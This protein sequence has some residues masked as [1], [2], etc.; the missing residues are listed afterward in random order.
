MTRGIPDGLPQPIP[1]GGVKP[2]L[3]VYLNQYEGE[4]LAV[5][6]EQIAATGIGAVKQPFYFQEPFDWETADRLVNAVGD[7][8]LQLV[9][10]LDGD[11]AANFAPPDD[12]NS[13]AAWAGAFAERYGDRLT[14]YI[15]WNEPNLASHW[16]GE[17]ANPAAYAALLTATAEAIRAADGNA[18]IV[19][20]PLAPTRE[21][22]PDNLADPLFLQELYEAGADDAFDVAAG[23]PYGFDSGPEDRVVDVDVLNF[24]RIILL[25]EV[26]VRNG[27]GHKAVWAGNWG[28][29]SLPAGWEGAP[30]I[31]G[32]TDPDTQATRTAGALRRARREWPWM[33]F[34]F[35]ENWEAT[36][37]AG[38][39][40]RGFSIAGRPAEQALATVAAE[41]EEGIA[42][43]GFHLAQGEGIGQ[44]YE[45][46][47]RFS[48]A[49]GADIPQDAD[50]DAGDASATLRFW[51]TDVGLRV[52]HADFR[53][54][55]YATVDGQPANALPR[56][57]NGPALVL[58]AADPAEDYLETEVVARN[59][60]PGEHTL[61]LLAHRGWDQWA[62]NGYTVAYHRPA[63]VY[64]ASLV[65]LLALAAGAF[66][67]AVWNAVAARSAL[68]RLRRLASERLQPAL[69]I[70]VAL[71]VAVS[72]WLTWG[73][74]AAGIYRRLSDGGQLALTAAAASIFYFTP[75]FVVYV[76]ALIA[77]FFL[78]YARPAWGVTLVA[79]TIPFYVK[80]KPMLGYRFS[81]VELFL[82]VTVTAW[83][84]HRLARF[85][86]RLRQEGEP[87]GPVE[88]GAIISGFRE[89]LVRADFAVG[90]FVAVA[91]LSLLFTERLDVAVNEWRVVI[92]EPALFYALL[93][94]V[95]LK[96]EE[97][98]R[99][100]DA[101]VLGGV[102]IALYGLATY[103]PE[104]NVVTVGGGL[105]R[106]KSL[107][108]SPN[109]VALYLGRVLPLLAAVALM[110]RAMPR[111]RLA[112]GLALAPVSLALV[113]TFSKGALFLGLPAALLLLFVV[114]QRD[115][116]RPVWPWLAGM[117]IVAAAA[118][119]AALNVPALASRLDL[120]SATSVFRLNLWQASVNMFADHPLF[121]VGL[122]NFLY[123]YRGRYIFDA[124]W[125]EPNLNHPHNIVLDFATRLGTLGLVTGGWLFWSLGR[126]LHQLSDRVSDMWRPVAVGLAAA[127]AN[128]LAHGLVD[129]SFFLVDLSF[130]FYLLLGVAVWLAHGDRAR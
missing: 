52:R 3:N 106:L 64:W 17:P 87:V 115:A 41:M 11:P 21:S 5:E 2:A 89:R 9:P 24:S 14:Y 76:V 114:W 58:T 78:V 29:N 123:A 84:A 120:R 119:V 113:L 80:P 128:M 73:E 57:E 93:R 49:F 25:R 19:A 67:V 100:L 35:L 48:P 12:P 30:S 111:R 112:Y 97:M 66:V 126:L 116:S 37:P 23:K 56:D 70:L 45:G 69:T 39:P 68:G 109:N 71:V 28:W 88:I 8:G 40:R 63:T 62:L 81:P 42:Y 129:H 77:L 60:E 44:H 75:F 92:V 74:Q 95:R 117:A 10:L 34:M 105:L 33:G 7:H 54:R 102:V 101:F 83:A 125:Q 107:F 79:F 31:W 98:Q 91:T 110:G 27:N 47:W 55:L 16:G 18:V 59:L 1:Y 99:V 61:Q 65:G 20:A 108:G 127:F 50:V 53:A 32:Q 104:G 124:A 118:L 46:A 22:G 4:T 121:G 86:Q 38:D 51:G 96:D 103:R 90:A 6:L 122:D 130:A 72:G 13:F 36:G 26:L 15:I 85:M 82:L 94:M 43:P